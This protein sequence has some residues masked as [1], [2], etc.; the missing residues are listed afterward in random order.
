MPSQEEL[1]VID[2]FDN[3]QDVFADMMG[4]TI[5]K[6]SSAQ[7]VNITFLRGAVIPLVDGS[8]KPVSSTIRPKRAASVTLTLEKAKR[9]KDLLEENLDKFDKKQAAEANKKKK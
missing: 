8:G 4:V 5:F 1:F 3:V 2:D 6:S 9:L 7:H